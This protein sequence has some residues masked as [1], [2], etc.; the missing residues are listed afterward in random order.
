MPGRCDRQ[1]PLKRRLLSTA[2]LIL[3]AVMAVCLVADPVPA[4]AQEQIGWAQ[5]VVNKVTGTLPAARE[6]VALRPGIE[7]FRNEVIDTAANSTAIVV[8]Q[9]DTQLSICAKSEVVLPDRIPSGCLTAQLGKAACFT[10]PSAV[11][12]TSGTTLTITV[13]A[14]GG[15]TVSVADGTVSVTGA[16]R[17]VTVAAGQSTVVLRGAAPTP[18]VPTP[19]KPPIVTEMDTL[20]TAASAQDFGTRAAARSPPS[21][22]PH[23]ADMFS[24][25]IDGKIQSEMIGD[26]F[27]ATRKS[28]RTRSGASPR[29]DC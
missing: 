7:V 18:P 4:R 10:T 6:P 25:N 27:A 22:A 24:P 26:C 8:F 2:L 15:T 3:L 16:G 9:D 13:S 17:T 11:A 12:C 21:E 20:L 19:P 5:R 29:P 23:G 1:A 28:S 14:R